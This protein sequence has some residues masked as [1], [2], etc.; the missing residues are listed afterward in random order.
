MAEIWPD[1]NYWSA[2]SEQDMIERDR[3]KTRHRRSLVEQSPE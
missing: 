3:I 2:K 1:T